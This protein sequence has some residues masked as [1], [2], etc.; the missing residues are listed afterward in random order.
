MIW[1]YFL[2]LTALIMSIWAMYADR[3]ATARRHEAEVDNW[4]RY[5]AEVHRTSEPVRC[6]HPEVI[7]VTTPVYPGEVVARLCTN[8]ECYAQ[9]P[10]DFEYVD[11][12]I[13]AAVRSR[14]GRG[15]H[16]PPGSNWVCS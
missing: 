3:A 16:E 13:R 8:P 6:T 15:L 2:S 7:D 1:I 10:A 4:T 11:P 12:A 9:L 5:D 14:L